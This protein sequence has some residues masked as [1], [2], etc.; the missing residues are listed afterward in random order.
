MVVTRWRA[1][2]I[3]RGPLGELPPTGRGFDVGGITMER[4]ADGRIAEVWVTRDELGL[5]RQLGAIA[6]HGATTV[7]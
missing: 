7:A 5:L 2:G 3:H 6:E 4:F 1:R